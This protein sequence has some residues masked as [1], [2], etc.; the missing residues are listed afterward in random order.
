MT[1]ADFP[2]GAVLTVG[3]LA[4]AVVLLAMDERNRR[5]FLTR[6]EADGMRDRIEKDL[7]IVHEACGRNEALFVALDDRTGDLEGRTSLMEERQSQHWER[8]GEEA[9]S[10]MATVREVASD[11]KETARMMQDI[12]LRL[13]RIRR[14]EGG[15]DGR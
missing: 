8:W 7:R 3:T 10:I 9:R 5:K 4:I 1:W 14:T 15:R 2:W 12:A 11:Q 6:D 13:E